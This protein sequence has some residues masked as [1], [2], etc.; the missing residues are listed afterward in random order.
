MYNESMKAAIFLAALLPSIATAGNFAA[1][2][3]DKLPGVQNDVAA[4][5]VYQ[6][7]HAQ[8][9]GAFGSVK[10]GDGRGWFSYKS[11]PDCTIEKASETRSIRAAGLIG[12]ACRRLYDEGGPWLAFQ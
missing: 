4:Q 5:A 8:H 6:V 1:C 10:Q 11:G 3:L 2:L 12:A 9:P 7:C